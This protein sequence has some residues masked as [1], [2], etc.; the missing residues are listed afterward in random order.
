[1]SKKNRQQRPG[2]QESPV[3]SRAVAPS[4]FS[5]PGVIVA[6]VMLVWPFLVIKEFLNIYPISLN[7]F[8]VFFT[9]YNPISITGVVSSVAGNLWP[10]V[11]MIVM[12]VGAYGWGKSLLSLLRVTLPSRGE[13]RMVSVGV[14]L[15]VLIYSLLGIGSLGML[16]RSVVAASMVVGIVLAAW[17][18]RQEHLN[19]PVV[20]KEKVKSSG[21]WGYLMMGVLLI[22]A[23]YT[24]ICV[25]APETFYDSLKY[26]LS[27]PQYWVD[28]HR[29]SIIEH[30]EYSYYPSN[31]HL[32]YIPMLMFG[33]VISA[34]FLHFA[35]AALCMAMILLWAQRLWSRRTAI[36]G[37]FIFA[38]TP[39]VMF[40]MW[41]SAIEFSLAFFELMAVYAVM[42][43]VRE[44]RERSAIWL[45][46]GGVFVGTAIGGKYLSVFALAGV[47]AVLGFDTIA[48]RLMSMRRLLMMLAVGVIALLMIS[49]YVIRNYQITGNPTY[50][51][52]YSFSKDITAT[53]KDQAVEFNDPATPDRS[54]RNYITLPWYIAMG[55]KTQ[56]PFSG[57]FFLLLLPLP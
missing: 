55:K 15:V 53:N 29:V 39:M 14:G 5:L 24:L 17:W 28:H 48:N 35:F 23:V 26:H 2:K 7:I 52:G 33:T 27:L 56:E 1:M 22:S 45:I 9:S 44:D 16:Y 42:Q 31:M 25:M 18:I 46:L 38:L 54:I 51:Y 57:M 37:V 34:K 4:T 32:M 13:E 40:L 10:S 8:S 43:A 30:F 12:M 21:F 11:P 50:P 19:T 20:P 6:G 36:T 47:G 49:P 41:R 3:V